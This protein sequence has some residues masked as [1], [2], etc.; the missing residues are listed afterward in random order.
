MSV[1]RQLARFLTVGLVNTLVGL[2]VIFLLMRLG[3][4]YVFANASG[5]A[6]GLGV[7][8]VLNRSWTFRAKSGASGQLA[9]YLSVFAVCYLLNLAVVGALIA[10]RFDPYFSQVL[11]I[12]VYTGLMFVGSRTLVFGLGRDEEEARKRPVEK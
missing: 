1:R 3:A 6:V 8:F 10:N 4:H 5:Y 12:G 2:A 9:R 11:G 7:S